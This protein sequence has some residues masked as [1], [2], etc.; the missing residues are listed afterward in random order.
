MNYT[1]YI[2]LIVIILF[3]SSQQTK[4]KEGY[5][6]L[7]TCE[8]QGYPKE[9]C[10]N[11]PVQSSFDNRC[12]CATGEW[13]IYESSSKCRCFPFTSFF[14]QYPPSKTTVS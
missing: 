5:D 13:G 10:L 4:V 6:S 11:V 9:F 7:T 1:L 14:S 12:R 8:D 2:S 3:V